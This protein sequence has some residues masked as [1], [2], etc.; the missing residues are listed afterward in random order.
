VEDK[1]SINA[2]SRVSCED[3]IAI[4]EFPR[5]NAFEEASIGVL[6]PEPGA[7]IACP[8]VQIGDITK[9]GQGREVDFLCR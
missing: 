8:D 7:A 5:L 4:V 1:R 9:I 2:S 3:K 6:C